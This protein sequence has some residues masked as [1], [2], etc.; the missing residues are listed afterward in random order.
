MKKIIACLFILSISFSCFAQKYLTKTAKIV[1]SSKT[2]LETIVGTNKLV[3]TLID[4]QTGNVD[5]I[6]NIKS[7]VFDKQ[8][9]QEH[10]NE[11]YLESDKLPKATFKGVITN[12][13]AISFNKNGEYKVEV[14]GKMTIHGVTKDVKTI[15]KITID[16]N[17]LTINADF[18]IPIEAYNIKIP[19]AVKDKISKDVTVIVDGIL[20]KK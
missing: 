16:G 5:F 7:F 10:F 1:F 2:P 3:A 9:M 15:G 19:G 14:S 18:K 12:L 20:I 6:V 17:A 8:L 11:N 13:A 4:A